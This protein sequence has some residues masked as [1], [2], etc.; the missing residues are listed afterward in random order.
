MTA[1]LLAPCL[2][3]G[4]MWDMLEGS[5]PRELIREYYRLRRRAHA[6]VRSADIPPPPSSDAHDPEPPARR[7]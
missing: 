3:T 4:P 6:L 5:E 7:S 2:A 1:R